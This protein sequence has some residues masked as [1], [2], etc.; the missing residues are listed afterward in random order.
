MISQLYLEAAGVLQTDGLPGLPSNLD[1]PPTIFPAPAAFLAAHM[2]DAARFRPN[3][4][5]L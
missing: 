5:P 3:S 4:L 1:L 2:G